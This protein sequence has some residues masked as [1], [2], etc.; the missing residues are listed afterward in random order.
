MGA[1]VS[2]LLLAL[3][4]LAIDHASLSSLSSR[5]TVP[6]LDR[7]LRHLGAQYVFSIILHKTLLPVS[8]FVTTMDGW[9]CWGGGGCG[10]AS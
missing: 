5:S 10:C 1:G 7:Q 2:H 6:T 8:P 9:Y 3:S 4:H